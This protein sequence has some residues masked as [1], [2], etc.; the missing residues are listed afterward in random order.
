[1]NTLEIAQAL[2]TFCREGKDNEAL[3]TLYAADAVSVEAADGGTGSRITQGVEGIY[4]KHQWWA[5]N[6]EVHEVTVSDPM[7]HGDGRFAVI[8]EMDTTHKPSNQRS[9]MQ[10]VAIYTVAD[11]KI[12][13]E[14]FFYAM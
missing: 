1:M 14:E 3:D 11:G 4:G 12:V 10:E 8:F 7:P 5:D 2:V 9:Q 13:R 6:F